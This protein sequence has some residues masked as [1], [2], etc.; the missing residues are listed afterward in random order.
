[1][2]QKSLEFRVQS[3]LPHVFVGAGMAAHILHVAY[4]PTLQATQAL[5]LKSAGYEVTSVLGNDNA[6]ALD[7]RVIAAADLV[8]VGFCAPHSVRAELVLWFKTQ[9]PKLPV[10]ALQSTRWE[11]FGEADASAFS[12]SPT[13]WLEKIASILKS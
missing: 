1:M 5:M 11:E 13:I 9:Y 10:V 4:Y 6:R 12:E 3:A 8:V 7:P 2:A